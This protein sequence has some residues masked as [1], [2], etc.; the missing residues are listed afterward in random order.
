MQAEQPAHV[1][2]LDRVERN[3][4]LLERR[5]GQGHEAV[6]QTAGEPIQGRHVEIAV[7]FRD[8]TGDLALADVV[9]LAA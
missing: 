7:G 6:E 5:H 2:R 4:P 3:V 9:G 1:L 8:Q